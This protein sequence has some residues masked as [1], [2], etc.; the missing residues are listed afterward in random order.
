MIGVIPD[1]E[2]DKESIEKLRS[3][4]DAMLFSLVYLNISYE[5][6]FSIFLLL[7]LIV[8]EVNP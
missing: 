5:G 4:G 7:N 1:F 3:G 6:K 8:P 2:L